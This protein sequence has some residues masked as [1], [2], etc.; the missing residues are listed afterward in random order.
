MMLKGDEDGTARIASG[1]MHPLLQLSLSLFTG[2]THLLP[3]IYGVN[4]CTL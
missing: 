3:C 2:M 4:N 1:S